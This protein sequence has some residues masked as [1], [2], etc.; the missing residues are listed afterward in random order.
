GRVK[1][2]RILSGKPLL[3]AAAIEAVR[4]W[5]YNPYRLNGHVVEAETSVSITFL[6]DD[7]V[8]MNFPS[9]SCGPNPGC[10]SGIRQNAQTT[11]T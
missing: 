3:T 2:I 7:A 11:G 6:G 4:Y 10:A 9:N 5:R 8:S 1:V